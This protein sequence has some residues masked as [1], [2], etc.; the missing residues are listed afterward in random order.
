MVSTT[1]LAIC[2]LLFPPLAA[3]PVEPVPESF[4]F[5][6]FTDVHINPHLSRTGEPGAPRGVECLDW[7]CS[8]VALPQEMPG[9]DIAAPAPVFALATGDLTEYGVIDDTWEVFEKAFEKLPIPTYVTPGNHD[10][11]WVSMYDIMRRLH[12]GENYSFDKYGYHFACI[13]SASPQ[14]PVPTIDAKTRAWLTSDLKRLPAGT[15]VF[16]ALH[17]PVY[18]NEF[19]NPA[20]Y[21][22]F[23]DLLRDYNIV[24]MIYG[25]GHSV[26]H[27]DMDGIDGIMGGSTFGKNAGYAIFCIS[28]DLLKVAYRYHRMPGPSERDSA[29]PGWKAVLTKPITHDPPQRLFSIVS[30][31]DGDKVDGALELKTT[32]LGQ[33]NP[34]V[35]FEKRVEIDGVEV[36]SV[37]QK[38]NDNSDRFA[39]ESL[40]PGQHLLTVRMKSTDSAHAASDLRTITFEVGAAGGVVAWRRAYPAA[41][42]AGLVIV[43]DDVIVAMTDGTVVALSRSRGT[44]TWKLQ[45]PAEVLGAPASSGDMLVLGAGDGKVYGIT[46]GRKHWTFDAEVPVYGVPLIDGDTVFVGDNGGRMHALDLD[47]GHE[48][49]VFERADY[50]IECR[51]CL[52]GD[53][54]VFGAWDGYLY[55]LNRSDGALAWKAFGPKS[56]DKNGNRYYAPADCG[57]VVLGDRLLVC[58]RGYALGSYGLDGSPGPRLGEKVA[59]IASDGKFIYSRGLE[60]RVCKFDAAGTE[61]WQQAVPAG[62]FPIP[63]TICGNNVYVCSNRGR[64]S[65]LDSANGHVWWEYQATPGFYVMAPLA[66]ADDG[67]CYVGGMDGSVTALRLPSR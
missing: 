39:T 9:C 44:V 30:P 8:E 1:F 28:E 29:Q 58:D 19:A 22:T 15:P 65:V 14:E 3:P 40:T 17:H 57:P 32:I 35:V 50:S 13:C 54:L 16:V 18:S 45:L 31:R 63:P 24:S 11:T 60:D 64:L 52:W 26:S 36:Q 66:V 27:R 6:Q 10:N 46:R 33:R 21:D 61:V 42:K 7:L 48:R 25:H 38:P 20:A 41:I 4:T 5:V 49:W 53:L 59:G 62:R 34:S 51:P 2:L 43:D 55:A 56:S 12:G 47:T 67:T 37:G 23:I